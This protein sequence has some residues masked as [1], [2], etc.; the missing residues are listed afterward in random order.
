M[1]DFY[2][3]SPLVAWDGESTPKIMKE[4]RALRALSAEIV[5]L[6]RGDH[7]AARL[8][9]ERERVLTPE[10]KTA[11]GV[12]NHFLNWKDHWKARE[13][14]ADKTLTPAQRRRRLKEFFNVT[15]SAHGH[16]NL[17]EENI[18]DAVERVLTEA[19]SK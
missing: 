17:T 1:L 19:E 18:E 8:K 12:L 4:L 7:C 16:T 15:V 14:F 6:R 13:V 2:D 10:H 3:T 11:D 5:E 9:P